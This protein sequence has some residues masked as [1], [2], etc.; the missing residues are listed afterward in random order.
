MCQIISCTKKLLNTVSKAIGR[1]RFIHGI[2]WSAN[3]KTVIKGRV[4]I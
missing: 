4:E 1:K 2:N 3:Y